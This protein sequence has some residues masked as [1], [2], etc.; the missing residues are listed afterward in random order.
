MS[1]EYLDDDQGQWDAI[2]MEEVERVVEALDDLIEEV[3]SDT[4][5][6]YLHA[7]CED[8]VRL[9][10]DEDEDEAAAA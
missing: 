5:K 10:A 6:M 4:I 7:V 1:T 9:V 8:I 3:H 2:D